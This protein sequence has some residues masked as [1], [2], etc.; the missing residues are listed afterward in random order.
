MKFMKVLV[1][2]DDECDRELL[3]RFFNKNY[4]G[5][6]VTYAEG[7][8]QGQ[9]Y[10][11]SR[12]FDL[13]LTDVQMHDGDGIDLAREAK[14]LDPKIITLVLSGSDGLGNINKAKEAGV[15][16]YL[17]KPLSMG[18]LMEAVE[19]VNE[20]YLGLMRKCEPPLE[21][22]KKKSLKRNATIA[23]AMLA[24]GVSPCIGNTCSA[25]DPH[26]FF[27]MPMEKLVQI[28]IL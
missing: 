10:L 5:N 6:S 12:D 14:K 23:T 24:L 7:F 21:E 13:L 16:G 4:I 1:V 8:E 27:S 19:R 15:A 20:L 25:Y 11:A 17:T 28:N 26:D 22:K 2:E 18:G 9:E 3:R